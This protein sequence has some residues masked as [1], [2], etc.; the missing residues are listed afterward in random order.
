MTAAEQML[1]TRMN[2]TAD[3]HGFI[4]EPFNV[5]LPIG[6]TSQSVNVNELIW[7]FFR[8]HGN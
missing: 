2:R 1:Y 5:G 3:R 4:A 8:Q 6:A 7:S